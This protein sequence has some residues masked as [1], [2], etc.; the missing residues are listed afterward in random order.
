[1]TC[2]LH[3]AFP[4]LVSTFIVVSALSGCLGMPDGP[5]IPTD[6]KGPQL[7][8]PE[9]APTLDVTIPPV[10]VQAL[11]EGEVRR[12]SAVH[13]I[14]SE[15]VVPMGTALTMKEMAQ[16]LIE[17][18]P[19][20]EGETRWL[21]DRELVFE[22]KAGW[23]PATVYKVRVRDV[24][25]QVAKGT[26]VKGKAWSFSTPLPQVMGS[27][28]GNGTTHVELTPNMSVTFNY[29]VLRDSLDV[30][31]V[32]DA[33]RHVVPVEL[34]HPHKNAKE[35]K[36]YTLWKV[37]PRTRLKANTK[38]T[39]KVAPGF[40]A[41]GGTLPA[42]KGMVSSFT[43]YPPAGVKKALCPGEC[44]ERG[45][46]EF[47]FH[48]RMPAKEL[49]RIQVSPKPAKFK[50]HTWGEESESATVRGRFDADVP[51]TF[52]VPAGV[53]DQYGQRTKKT[54]KKTYTF[55][56]APPMVTLAKRSGILAAS[57]P[58][59]LAVNTRYIGEL[60]AEL[61]KV[62]LDG[63]RAA[64]Q[65]KGYLDSAHF[66]NDLA[67][68]TLKL[69]HR[70]DAKSGRGA[71]LVDMRKVDP[72]LKPGMYHLR[73]EGAAKD[74]NGASDT[75]NAFIQVTDLGV[76]S[77]FH[78]GRLQVHV[79]GIH[80]TTP[81]SGAS[82][83]WEDSRGG[84]LLGTTDSGGQIVVEGDKAPSH[85][86]G[87]LRVRKGKDEVWAAVVSRLPSV[88]TE[89][90]NLSVW[91]ERS[92][93]QP[94][95]KVHIMGQVTRRVVAQEAQGEVPS[96]TDIALKIEGLGDAIEASTKVGSRGRFHKTITIPKDAKLGRLSVRATNK[97][98]DLDGYASAQVKK[99][100]T[101]TFEVKA[102]AE[103]YEY[104]LG[105]YPEL[106]VT[107]N[108]FSGEPVPMDKF[109]KRLHCT[110][111][112]PQLL[113]GWTTGR[114]GRWYGSMGYNG[115]FKTKKADNGVTLIDRLRVPPKMAAAHCSMDV[116]V[117][118]ASLQKYGD[119]VSWISYGDT[120]Y[121][122]AKVSGSTKENTVTVKVRAV[123][124]EGKRHS[125]RATVR[126]R[127]KWYEREGGKRGRR[128]TGEWKEKEKK[129]PACKLTLPSQGDDPSC[130]V[131]LNKDGAQVEFEVTLDG[132]NYS[133]AFVEFR[134]WWGRSRD[135]APK[136]PFRLEVSNPVPKVGEVVR[137]E[138]FFP[139]KS[140]RGRLLFSRSGILKSES[141]TFDGGKWSTTHKVTEADAGGLD[142]GLFWYEEGKKRLHYKETWQGLQ[143]DEEHRRLQVS[144]RS[145]EVSKPGKKEKVS[146]S[147]VDSKG[148]KRASTLSLWAVDDAVLSLAPYRAPDLLQAHR[149]RF[150][151]ANRWGSN[152]GQL[153]TPD[154]VAVISLDDVT[155]M[156]YGGLGMRGRGYGAGGAMG[157]SGGRKRKTRSHFETTPFFLGEVQT[158][159][160][161]TVSTEVQWPD[162]LSRFVLFAVATA[163]LEGGGP[164]LFGTA[165]ASV[166]L[167]QDVQ[168]RL[169]LP[170][171]VRP[172]DSSEV[173]ALVTNAS[174][175]A[176]TFDVKLTMTG[177]EDDSLSTQIDLAPGEQKRVPWRVTFKYDGVYTFSAEAVTDGD[178]DRVERKVESRTERTLVEHVAVYGTLDGD[179]VRGVPVDL[180]EAVP[181]STELTLETTTSRLGSLSGSAE[182]LVEYPHGCAEQTMSRILPMALL[183]RVSEV[184][185]MD[186][187]E[188]K[189]HVKAG[190]D[191]LLSMQTRSGGIAYWPGGQVPH[192]YASAYAYFVLQE[193]QAGGFEV[194]KDAVESLKAY[195]QKSLSN[196]DKDWPDNVIY[197]HD[198]RRALALFALSRT[199]DAP[200]AALDDVLSRS[201]HLTLSARAWL[202]LALANTDANDPRLKKLKEQ[203]IN[204]LS[205]NAGSAWAAERRPFALHDFF[206]SDTK[207]TATVLMALMQTA[208]GSPF[209]ERL[210]YGLDLARRQGRWR[211]TQDHAFA[212]WAM[213][214]YAETYEKT[215]PSLDVRLWLGQRR[216]A[217][218]H[219]EGHELKPRT[220]TVDMKGEETGALIL[221]QKGK[222]R[223]Y[224]RSD[225]AYLPSDPQPINRGIELTRTWSTTAGESPAHLKR[226]ETVMMKVNVR[227]TTRQAYVAIEVPIPSGL[228]PRLN[229]ANER[230]FD[231]REHGGGWVS[232][233]E[234]HPDRLLL[235]ADTLTTGDHTIVVGLRATTPGQYS[236]PA[237]YAHAM[238]QPDV[239][240]R[241]SSAAVEIK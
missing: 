225:I 240:G 31:L 241:S 176:R 231:A 38:Y 153:V 27:S 150:S 32:G 101:P 191:R 158:D 59:T 4:R 148:G 70:T 198:M 206:E 43:T 178:G 83:Y 19:A 140:G 105:E 87:F 9:A 188:S 110:K 104:A 151:R 227:T 238:Y 47:T 115:R 138:A 88:T 30:T 10:L 112:Q 179:A 103:K 141:F 124:I 82:V 190:I 123:D 152:Y 93:Y 75:A 14:Y 122:A 94:G 8:A 21:T 197:Y 204:A 120:R 26:V 172:G 192:F 109:E 139:A 236:F 159:K 215:S 237:A 89:R 195:L 213:T 177:P 15:S 95:E 54:F 25:S 167:T 17:L 107:A 49:K 217:S 149:T 128:D 7:A 221:Q 79:S 85:H 210:V 97:K 20:V 92:I 96:G 71:A 164:G 183:S 189:T 143:A 173:S 161:G 61:G 33:G 200:K 224:Y 13:V 145:P 118:D 218:Q 146:V 23:L 66:P 125:A 46:V 211:T 168:A 36:A 230:N 160:D 65:K 48:T 147:I 235:Y 131:K 113:E 24:P 185:P 154:K 63:A 22:P 77:H 171:Q 108:Y 214:H 55:L 64:L 53:K 2:D 42:K 45:E 127:L 29:P 50:V 142:V 114:Y 102:S 67:W 205:L 157:G 202:T 41:L 165:K 3:V 222:G 60:R 117:Q 99:F 135:D 98:L 28:P 223:T 80:D 166:V 196:P 226:G 72:D 34:L 170:R 133:E 186:A 58:L 90:W 134:P 119:S 228:E 56:K 194:P 199:N 129:L 209:I 52:V 187:G 162:N 1:M 184:L 62:N 219:Y 201:E 18:E 207:T 116:S 169:N 78:E 111:H 136:E 193:V 208:P 239:F 69:E 144:L 35:L 106:R 156:G 74:P 51:Y 84:T 40:R 233:Q 181:G 203:M 76:V 229:L 212:L 81:V 130:T 68:K 121:A 39:L 11:P 155:V 91:T 16:G 132:H 163:D 220:T 100:R 182:T 137:L 73:V 12:P 180:S 57:Q 44:L 216:V 234:R 86:E 37:K 232:H 6:D 175:E 5:P 174:K 126:P